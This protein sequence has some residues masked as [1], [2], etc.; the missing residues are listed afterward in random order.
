MNCDWPKRRRRNLFRGEKETLVP[1]KVAYRGSVIR[2][3]SFLL[4]FT[5]TRTAPTSHL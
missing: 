2:V 3:A 4:L 5:L 1:G